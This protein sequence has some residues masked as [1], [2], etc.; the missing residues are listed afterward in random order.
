MC[1]DVGV[2]RNHHIIS[3]SRVTNTNTKNIFICDIYFGKGNYTGPLHD[4]SVGVG[5]Y[6]GVYG[7]M[8]VGEWRN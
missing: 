2:G 7:E 1:V 4:L 8:D 6:V 5:V 3:K